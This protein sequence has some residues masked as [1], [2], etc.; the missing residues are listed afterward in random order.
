[1]PLKPKTEVKLQHMWKGMERESQPDSCHEGE[2]CHVG[3]QRGKDF[4]QIAFE[5][6]ALVRFGQVGTKAYGFEIF[7]IM[8]PL[9]FST[10][11]VW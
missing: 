11:Q 3:E 4:L 1:M 8:F 6:L 2:R 7:P 10:C 5:Q 9:M